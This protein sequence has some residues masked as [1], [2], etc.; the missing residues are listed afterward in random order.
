M[1]DEH[2][3]NE[4][5]LARTC[6]KDKKPFVLPT[7]RV[8]AV[9]FASVWGYWSKSEQ[10]QQLQ[11]ANW[12]ATVASV[13]R[14]CLS[15]LRPSL[16]RRR[17]RNSSRSACSRGDEPGGL[18]PRLHP[19]VQLGPTGPAATNMIA[20]LAACWRLVVKERGGRLQSPNE[21]L[22][23]GTKCRIKDSYDQ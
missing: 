4:G 10:R 23:T 2:R 8:G 1:L 17:E 20:L 13:F 7:L 6:V 15:G 14:G 11:V 22:S 12:H 16:A 3:E 5:T 18:A 21:K 9:I 19:V